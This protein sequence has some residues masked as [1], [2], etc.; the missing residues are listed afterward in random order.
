MYAF[1]GN[2]IDPSSITLFCVFVKYALLA[3]SAILCTACQHEE[4]ENVWWQNEK[5]IT[6][7]E[8]E[9]QLTRFKAAKLETKP[10]KKAE[11]INQESP[12]LLKK[13]I[14][15]MAMR[16]DQLQA[17]IDALREGKDGFRLEVLKRRRAEVMGS[18]FEELTTSDGRVH[19]DVRITKIDDIGV[20]L[21]HAGGIARLGYKDL[22]ESEQAFFG[23]DAEFAKMA[24][25]NERTARIAYDTWVD[26]SVAANKE[27]E[28]ML[29]EARRK[30]S[31]RLESVKALAAVHRKPKPH[32]LADS[33]GA[34]GKT[35]TFS[36]RGYDYDRPSY[37]RR[38]SYYNFTT[39][40]PFRSRTDFW[41]SPIRPGT[42]CYPR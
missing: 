4:S 21:S 13:E 1:G 7:L 6:E 38:S 9:L 42:G 11:P 41:A 16:I 37:R 36:R 22:N 17:E 40:N 23:I 12:E 14:D 5:T 8:Q 26:K 15:A 2:K 25:A 27:E 35:S 19:K 18:V 34:L 29:A 30:E 39:P 24:E 3:L 28:K 31:N 10:V 32:P 33:V 20:S